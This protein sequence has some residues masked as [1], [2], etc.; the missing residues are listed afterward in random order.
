MSKPEIYSFFK[1]D[2]VTLEDYEKLEAQLEA[3]KTMHDK[4]IAKWEE[5]L[6]KYH[7]SQAKLDAVRKAFNIPDWQDCVN[8]IKTALGDK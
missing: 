1:G 6:D 4:A 2:F 3:E 5:Y 7:A 8:A